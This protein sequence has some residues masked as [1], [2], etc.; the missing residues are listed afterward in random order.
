MS[1]HEQGES[2]PG[3]GS[4]SSLTRR[5]AI[6]RG[7]VAGAAL[8]SGP[9]LLASAACSS[10]ETSGGTT[11]GAPTSGGTLRVGMLGS[12]SAE[13]LNP[14]L[15]NTDVDAARSFQVFQGFAAPSPRAELENTLA[16]E[17]VPNSDATVWTIRLR[18]GIEFHNGKTLTSDDAIYT[19][20][21]NLD[22]ANAALGAGQLSF[23]DER[24]IKKVDAVTLQVGLKQP[25]AFFDQNLSDHHIKIFPEGTT[26]FDSPVGTGP[27][28][29]VD[30]VQGQRGE[31]TRN[32][33]YW[34]SGKPHLDG[35]EILSIVD[36][37]ARINALQSGQV[38]VAASIPL[39]SVSA[40]ENDPNLTLLETEALYFIDQCMLTSGAASPPCD[41]PRVRQ[42]LRLLV[43]RQ[44]VVENALL[45]H[46]LIGN[47]MYQWQDDAYPQDVPQREYD[48][49]QAASLLR[50]AGH[51]N[52]TIDLYTGAIAP[53]V[54]QFSQLMAES[55]KAAG[56]TI[57]VKNVPAG[58]FFAGP[59]RKR[60]FFSSFGN[61]RVGYIVLALLIQMPNAPLNETNWDD[62]EYTNLLSQ[63][64]ATTDRPMAYELLRESQKIL[65]DRGG[66]LIPAFPN[67]IDGTS[68]NVTGLVPSYIFP[69]GAFR[70][71][72]VSLKA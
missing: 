35:V 55:A 51:E 60:P 15:V 68:K 70:F 32:E 37:Q 26:N 64:L 46:G 71:E 28:K 13:T 65:W 30:W 48:P 41:D 25:H 69:L 27:F 52:L 4:G 66:Y 8:V 23:V 57:N 54:L 24:E 20:Q 12:G 5:E 49:E 2:D 34:E 21:Y 45:G 29:F 50:A 9:S 40:V 17:I 53:G 7:L 59:Y 31:Y 11:S 1:D 58:N 67:L 10:S 43:D 61:G 42:A 38:D 18:R 3:H 19:L 63:A 44:Q 56:V 14:C 72:D 47:D 33:N 16:E 6:Q 39:P 22:P 62:P 36:D